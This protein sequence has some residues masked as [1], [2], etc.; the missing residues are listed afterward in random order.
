MQYIKSHEEHGISPL[1][2]S[3]NHNAWPSS[4]LK[5]L[6]DGKKVGERTFCIHRDNSL[7]MFSDFNSWDKGS[8]YVIKKLKTDKNLVKE[9]SLYS[10]KISS[11]ILKIIRSFDKEDVAVWSNQKISDFLL[12]SYTKGNDLCAYGYIPVLSDHFF[13]KFTSLLKS[14]IKEK[15]SKSSVT[16][17]EQE[18]ISILS[19]HAKLIPSKVAR[20]ELLK[21]IKNHHSKKTALKTNALIE[22]SYKD[23]YWVNFGQLGD[24]QSWPEFLSASV[25]LIKNKKIAIKELND[26]LKYNTQL[27]KQQSDLSKQLKLNTEEKYLF[28]ICREFTFL[29]GL[30]MEVLYGLCSVWSKVLVEISK[31]LK[32]EKDLLYYASVHELASALSGKKLLDKK[33]LISRRKFCVWVAVSEHKQ[34]ILSGQKAKDFL[35]KINYKKEKTEKN[36]LVIHGTVASLGYAK[37]RVKIVNKTSEISKVKEGDIMVSMAT[38]PGLLP[39]M[40]KASAFITDA[41]GITSHAAIVAREMKKPCIIGT[42]IATKVLKDGDMIEIDTKSGD[43][44]KI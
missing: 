13:H 40:K 43:I 15:I 19:S 22:K 42:K 14:I 6:L 12:D 32:I 9:V 10:N 17:S 7:E 28:S 37:G 23:W 33:E 41:G 39:A 11:Q 5:K 24:C 31:R 27:K 3:P 44:K 25:D 16:L 35:K 4:I 18:L 20:I 2:I 1:T 21:I 8:D 38:H 34:I 26:L 29:K 30:R 36:V